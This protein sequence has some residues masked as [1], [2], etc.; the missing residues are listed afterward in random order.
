PAPPCAPPSAPMN[1]QITSPPQVIDAHR[2]GALVYRFLCIPARRPT[3]TVAGS[4]RGLSGA[5][6]AADIKLARPARARLPAGMVRRQLAARARLHQ[7]GWGRAG[8]SHI[9]GFL[10][11]LLAFSAFDPIPIST[12]GGGDEGMVGPPPPSNLFTN[13]G[14][15][16]LAKPPRSRR[17]AASPGA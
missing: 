3:R 1:A 10:A 6:S 15:A 16:P 14:C 5:C 12:G 9:G 8:D 17:P 13:A 4:R 2:E 11:G 7:H